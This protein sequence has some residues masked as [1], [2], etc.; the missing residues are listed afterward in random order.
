MS[1]SFVFGDFQLVPH[2]R[3]LYCEGSEVAL[4]SRAFDLLV[5]L[6]EKPGNVVTTREMMRAAWPG[7]I[8]VESNIRVQIANLR[9]IL[10][11][12]R[13]GSRYI[14]TV[15]GRGYCFVAD[16]DKRS[17]SAFNPFS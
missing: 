12:H 16:V 13:D 17:A 4:G 6:V 3:S 9:R 5:A 14:A 15:A 7:L 8:V 2:A 11:R 1:D 10:G